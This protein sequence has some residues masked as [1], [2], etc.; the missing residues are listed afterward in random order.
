MLVPEAYVRSVGSAPG[1]LSAAAVLLIAGLA[2][3]GLLFSAPGALAQ[4]GVTETEPRDGEVLAQPPD[5]LRLCFTEPVGFEDSS[6]WRFNLRAPDGISLGLR[7]QFRTDG[8]CV[9]VFPGLPSESKKGTWTFSW[10]VRSQATGE[11][12]S[13]TVNF[14]VGQERGVAGPGDEGAA[15]ESGGNGDGR[16][17]VIAAATVAG[18]V[19]VVGGGALFV[20]RRGSASRQS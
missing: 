17:V 2:L 8:E 3:A 6:D 19:V 18:L 4:V 13:G 7:V 15:G 14:I 12:G 16:A 9:E 5:R 11:E 20:R 10:F 1:V